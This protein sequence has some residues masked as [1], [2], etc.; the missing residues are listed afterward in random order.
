MWIE[1]CL[2]TCLTQ[3]YD[4]YEVI[5]VDALS[6]D[7]T[8]EIAKEYSA[9]FNRLKIFQNEIRLPQVANFFQLRELSAPNSIMVSVDGDDC[10]KGSNVL[11]KLNDVYN[12]GEVWLSYGTYTEFHGYGLP[13]RSVSHIYRKYPD[14]VISNNTF[15]EYQW[16]GSHLRTF[17]KNLFDKV[18]PDDCKKD[19]G[20]WL[21]TC[22]DI[23]I[24]FP[25]LEMAYDKSR[26]VSDILYEY[27]VANTFRD[28]A[29]NEKR[30]I[31]LDRYVRAKKRYQKIETL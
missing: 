20:Q 12:S 15:R 16:L 18:N 9:K 3:K 29:I 26:Y 11:S 23:A 1:K 13:L 25:M 19:D 4:N 14:E 31:E 21:D 30:Q 8:Y 7:K 24:M 10:L 17:R 28:G 2:K 5:L 27:N 6:D 22:G